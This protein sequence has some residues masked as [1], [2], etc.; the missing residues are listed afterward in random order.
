M[1]EKKPTT[2][3]HRGFIHIRKDPGIGGRPRRRRPPRDPFNPFRPRRPRPPRDPFNPFRPRRP[4]IPRFPFGRGRLGPADEPL[5]RR[6]RPIRSPIQGGRRRPVRTPRMTSEQRRAL[7]PS[8]RRLMQRQLRT[9]AR[10]RGRGTPPKDIGNIL[11]RQQ[12]AADN[13]RRLRDIA[14]R[15]SISAQRRAKGGMAFK[16]K[17]YVNPSNIM[18]NKKK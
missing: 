4:R 7:N 16:S 18:D 14:F 12:R 13:F 1:A 8:Q 3:A 5:D 6:G 15:R 11:A 10:E 2:K 17:D 9:I